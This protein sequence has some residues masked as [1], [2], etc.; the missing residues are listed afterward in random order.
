MSTYV[1]VDALNCYYGALKGTQ[2]KWLDYAALVRSLLPLDEIGKIRYFTANVKPLGPG[3]KSHERQAAYL[4]AL[5][6]NPLIDLV[7]GSFRQDDDWL[8]LAE[9]KHPVRDLF[10]P[11]LRP[12]TLVRMILSDAGKRRMSFHTL[13]RVIV[14]EEKGSDVSLGAYLVFDAL[15]GNC[16]KALVM[17]N[18]S[19]L[20]DAVMLA[21]SAGIDVGIV[22][23]H[24]Q[25]TNGVLLREATFEIPFR[26]ATLESC[27][28]PAIVIGKNGKEIHKPREW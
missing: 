18:D 27:Q 19:D 28:L 7:R 14:R 16:S 22:N 1:Y 10:R 24:R 15:Q 8:P 25:P 5:D 21:K 20:K 11:R 6:A 23:P 3:D 13:S 12:T 2:Y 9:E 26:P 4:R 17:S